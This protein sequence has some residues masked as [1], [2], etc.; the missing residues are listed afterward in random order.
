VKGTAYEEGA[1]LRDKEA[2]RK[3]QQIGDKIVRLLKP[4]ND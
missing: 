4:Q 2:V 1:V 3:A